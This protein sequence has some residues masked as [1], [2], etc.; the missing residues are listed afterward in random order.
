MP[1]T[2]GSRLGP[3][4]I[5]SLLGAGGFGE[6]Y[7]ARDTRLDR[8]VAI[9][10]LPSS[11]PELKVRFEREAKAIAALTHPHICTLYDVGHQDGTDYLVMEYLEG[12]TLEQRLKKGPLPIADALRVAIQIVDA[13][14]AAH[15]HGFVHR[16]LKPGNVM[17][18]KTGA[19][20]LDFGLAKASHPSLGRGSQAAASVTGTPTMSV[21]LTQ[22]GS[23]VGTFQ[24]M[25]PE[26]LEGHEADARTDIFAFGT[27]V[28]EMVSGRRAFEGKSQVSIIAAIMD[29]DPTSLSSLQPITPPLLDH[30]VLICLRKD[31]DAR[32]QAM[33]DVGIQLRLIAQSDTSSTRSAGGTAERG[34]HRWTWL[35][36]L[37]S[38]AVFG[39]VLV[40]ALIGRQPSERPTVRFEVNVGTSGAPF[41]FALSPDGRRLAWVE[42][43]DKGAA[44]ATRALDQLDSRVLLRTESARVALPF[45][46]PDSRSI[47]FFSTGKLRRIPV[48]GG[49]AEIICDAV[50]GQGGSWNHDGV[51]LFAPEPTGPLFQV[52]A[53]GGVP[54]PVTELDVASS[55]IAHRHPVFLPDG[56]HFLY[57]AVSSRADRSSIVVGALGSKDRRRLLTSVAKPGFAPPDHVLFVRDTSLMMQRLDLK[58]LT[59]VGDAV[60]LVENVGVNAG[61]S[62]AGF[63]VSANGVLA[64]RPGG[65]VAREPAQL[66]W[67]DRSGTRTGTLGTPAVY[68]NLALSPDLHAI[69]VVKQE[70][71]GA[72]DVWTIDLTSGRA[73]RF[74]S[75]GAND[76]VWSPDGTRIVFASDHDAGRLNLYQK[77]AGGALVEQRLLKSDHVQ[78]PE[79]WSADG[80]FLLFRDRDSKTGNDLWVLPMMADG[81][82]R[83]YLRSP[84]SEMQGRFS[85]NGRWVAYVSDESG[86][87]QVYIQSFP[88]VAK[89]YAVSTER[90]IQPRW[91]S[92]GRE[93]F[94]LEQTQPGVMTSVAAVDVVES[95]DGL[96]IGAQRTLFQS[97][98]RQSYRSRSSWEVAPDG[99]RFL[100]IES[101]QPDSARTQPITVLVD[102]QEELKHRVATK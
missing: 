66:A 1:L 2:A 9:K 4:D 24:Y 15:R 35:A 38:S 81:K 23:I 102:W 12:E 14:S 16:D 53:A 27:L 34:R 71:G 63:T 41:H 33:A 30:L 73:T 101:T 18:T 88:E 89:K 42:S 95:K 56:K 98:I 80:R 29:H 82:P 94:F 97:A 11:D 5:L 83:P 78:Q 46:S 22:H 86:R 44:I 60:P 77:N 25:A 50:G 32:W 64:W 76:P 61:T 75:D 43:T 57:L 26:Q 36:A 72:G 79:D 21:P 48:D 84:F 85:P 47:A 3:Y 10:I 90:G 37:G 17:L 59:F 31:P 58:G 96:S 20:L 62:L 13:L 55:E 99:H 74:T 40:A 67:L 7:K 93:L 39:G 92:D 70:E 49:P 100:I 87:D 91:S 51:I 6:V 45:W 65:Y 54:A 28:Y 68:D 8:T 52:S 19:K 69:A